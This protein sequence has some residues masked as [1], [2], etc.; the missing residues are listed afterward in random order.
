V[1]KE[2]KTIIADEADRLA[3]RYRI[4]EKK[5]VQAILERTAGGV[6]QQPVPDG[7]YGGK[8]LRK[9][10]T[11][12]PSLHEALLHLPPEKALSTFERDDLNILAW[13]CFFVSFFS[14]QATPYY[15]LQELADLAK[16]FAT[17]LGCNEEHLIKT[18]LPQTSF[19]KCRWLD[20]L[21][22]HLYFEKLPLCLQANRSP[23]AQRIAE[24]DGTATR[25]EEGNLVFDYSWAKECPSTGKQRWVKGRPVMKTRFARKEVSIPLTL[26][27]YKE[28]SLIY[29]L[30]AK[31][32]AWILLGRP[33]YF[34]ATIDLIN[35]LVSCVGCSCKPREIFREGLRT[36]TEGFTRDEVARYFDTSR[37][38]KELGVWDYL[39][40]LRGWT[41]YAARSPD[42]HQLFYVVGEFEKESS[43]GTYH[44]TKSAVL[45]VT[46]GYGPLNSYYQIIGKPFEADIGKV[47][48]T[49][50]ES[51]ERERDFWG[52]FWNRVY[53][54]LKNE[55]RVPVSPQILIR[56]RLAE[57]YSAV[58]GPIN[59]AQA[60][61]LEE[62]DKF[63]G[64][65]DRL[66][67]GR[68][69][70]VLS[71]KQ[72]KDYND[73]KYQRYDRI[74]IPG[75]TA[76]NRR[77]I[78][79]VNDHEIKIGD[80]LFLIF[81]RLVQELKEKKGGWVFTSKLEEDTLV[82]GRSIYQRCDELRTKLKVGLRGD[83][84]QNLIENRGTKE[85]R[86]STHPDFVTYDRKKLRKDHPVDRVR[87][88]AE[89]LR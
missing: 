70:V 44:R 73:Y 87:S 62:T 24:R 32:A 59:I 36:L 31:T 67:R 28:A 3:R 37:L 13:R 14:D 25:D 30:P 61:S 56:A 40:T 69:D 51:L 84:S 79:I 35:T 22:G 27:A 20:Y 21:L 41:E 53:T 12:H 49:F 71:D 85:Y 8:T 48:D 17:H 2:V 42:I 6:F 19:E 60:K 15:T 34:Q 7:I 47:L 83:K 10:L 74:E 75:D 58:M 66:Q 78:I 39:S 18:G 82:G 68:L 5:R 77:S 72:E 88:I 43:I 1:E 63:M 38:Y 45:D 89:K 65:D 11:F 16:D 57:R 9:G 33:R 29:G 46:R 26:C 81:L 4:K 80:S 23:K 54:A 64:I 50:P 76:G 55:F 52:R 86:I